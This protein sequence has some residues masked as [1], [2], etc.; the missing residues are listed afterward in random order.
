MYLKLDTHSGS[1]S[2]KPDKRKLKLN[3]SVKKRISKPRLDT[4]LLL[5][6]KKISMLFQTYER[7]LLIL[8]QESVQG[9][10]PGQSTS[11]N[12]TCAPVF[13]SRN[14]TRSLRLSMFPFF[15]LLS[16]SLPP[17]PSNNNPPRASPNLY[18]E[19]PASC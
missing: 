8:Y 3:F 19:L 1:W 17:H 7:C 14:L 6:F 2:S 11:A 4:A 18:A 12:V 9:C 10:R 13:P 16:L 15:P 5:T